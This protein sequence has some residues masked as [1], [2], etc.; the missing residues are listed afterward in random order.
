MSLGTKT[1]AQNKIFGAI[2]M[3]VVLFSTLLFSSPAGASTGIN[4]TI[5]F[6]GRLL[7]SQGATVPDGYY[8][9][10]FKIYQDGDGLSAA[11]STGS[12]SGTLDW[13]E[14]Y[15]NYN[16]QG[17]E[18]VNG[19]FSV[20]LGSINP[21]GSSVN[22][23]QDTLWLSMNVAGTSA[24][25]STFS[26]CSP[27][28]ELLPMQRL[29]AAPYALNS[30]LLDGIS[31][32][33]FVQIAQGLQTDA[34][35]STSI[36]LN[37]SGSG[38]IVD[39]Q[40]GGN[41][42]FII[43]NS[44]DINFGANA[45]HV[46]SVATAGSGVAGKSLTINSGSAGSGGSALAG[47]NLIV[48]AGAGGGTN[49]AG[50]SVSIDAGVHNGSG[51]DGSIT[52]GTSN[53]TNITIGNST[54]TTNVQGGAVNIATANVAT[55]TQIG[56]TSNG[57]AQTINIGNNATAGS[58]DTIKIGSTVAGTTTLQSS[59]VQQTINGSSITVSSVGSNNAATFVVNNTGG[60][61]VFSV[62]T[63][64]NQIALGK[65]GAVQG[66]VVF[67][68]SAGIHTATLQGP[69]L[70]PA[71]SY[72]LQLPTS[73]PSTNLCLSTGPTTASQ[74]VYVTCAT[75]TYLAKNATDTSSA[76]VSSSSYLYAFTNSS[77]AVAA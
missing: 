26:A 71:S 5:E 75:G 52:I 12:P 27:D 59:G 19:F 8:N 58:S 15:L 6:Q 68:D 17:V 11:D 30:N 77:S 3:V 72:T 74:L 38:N 62:D 1:K 25:C 7:N 56:N 65:A 64:G 23:N 73:A 67:D 61:S 24:I 20:D 33:N 70:D 18:V 63:T 21:F 49:G 42:A 28:G 4:Q 69:S 34:S 51:V 13:T 57:V 53:A 9:L 2:L 40:S 10:E 32:A 31:S 35:S 44:G 39:L 47:G 37:K 54:D 46:L 36:Y 22:W 48:A 66:G 29:T 14:N 76:A 55:T 45:N 43:N 16:S 60:N 41:D 50:G